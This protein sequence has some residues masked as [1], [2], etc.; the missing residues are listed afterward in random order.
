VEQRR[1][2]DHDRGGATDGGHEAERRYLVGRLGRT[3]VALRDLGQPRDPVL[4]PRE[5]EVD[6]LAAEDFRLGG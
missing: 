3:V 4:G 2:H 5:D 6:D 1:E